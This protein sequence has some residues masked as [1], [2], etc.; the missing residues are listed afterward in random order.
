M[1]LK[2]VH[3]TNGTLSNMHSISLQSSDSSI[4]VNDILGRIGFAASNETGSDA[5][6]V[7]ALILA[8]AE[9]TFDTNNNPTSLTFSTGHSETATEKMRIDS[10]GNVGIGT[11]YTSNGKLTVVD[12]EN[13]RVSIDTGGNFGS[14]EIGIDFIDRHNTSS[15]GDEGQIGAF[16]RS[17]RQGTGGSFDLILGTVDGS[18]LA[19]D[20]DEK[21][22]I[23]SEGK[24]GIA[25]DNPANKLHI[26]EDSSYLSENSYAIKISDGNDPETHGML[27]GVDSTNNIASIQA[28]DPGTSWGRNL[29]LQVMGG[30]L[31][32]GTTAPTEKLHLAGG[33]ILLSA[34]AGSGGGIGKADDG[35]HILFP[36]GGTYGGGSAPSVTGYIKIKLPVKSTSTM[37]AFDL[38]IYEYEDDVNGRIAKFRIAGYEYNA[39]NW[40][41]T[42][43]VMDSD[44]PT[45]NKYKVTF[46]VDTNGDKAIWISYYSDGKDGVDQ[47]GSSLWRYPKVSMSNLFCGHSS[48]VFTNWADGWDVGIVAASDIGSIYTSHV[49]SRSLKLYESS[50]DLASLTINSDYT[51]PTVDGS[52]NQL[53]KTNGAG[54]LSFGS[55]DDLLHGYPINYATSVGWVEGSGSQAG[56][57]GGDFG[58]NGASAENFCEFGDFPNSM[59]GLI[60]KSRNNT[61]DSGADGGWNKDI[62]G[63]DPEKTYISIV[64]VRRVGSNTNGSFYHG[65]GSTSGQTETLAGVSTT[66]PYFHSGGLAGLPQDVWCV[67]IGIIHAHSDPVTTST[68]VGGVYRLDTGAR[69]NFS[70][71]QDFRMGPST[72]T[73]RHRTYLYYDATGNSKL[74]WCWPGFYDITSPVVINLLNNLL[75]GNA[76]NIDINDFN[77]SS[78]ITESEGIS[79]NDNDTTLPTSAAVKDY[80]DNNGGSSSNL[81]RGSFAVTSSTTVFTVSGGYNTGSL[82]VYQNGIKLFKGS[83]YDYTET[84]GGTT[85]TLTN[86]ATNGDLIEYVA[87]NASTNAVGNTS[88]GSVSVTSNQTV[89][90]TTD[91]FTSSNLAV[92]LNGV[93]LVDGTDYN[94]TSSSQFTL[95]ST[96]VSGDIVEYIAYGATVASSNLSKTGDTMTGNLTVNADLIVTGYKETHTDNGNT[97]TSQTI[98]IS[99]STLQTYT[100]TGNCTFTMPTA[101]EGRSFTMFLKTGAGSFVATFTNAKFARNSTPTITT[102]ANRM[103]IITFYSDGTNWYGSIQQEYHI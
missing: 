23:T 18:T 4:A 58:R 15:Q 33:N 41:R 82:D 30:N 63:L 1:L 50:Y 31:G 17:Q 87:I 8:V 21:V 37:I 40:T 74:D 19:A 20:A 53:L 60:W 61:T 72:T 12:G 88:L 52:A 39:T 10:I 65:C 100:L 101:E 16:V 90:N 7:S 13:T 24:V 83:S 67:S 42:Q 35:L 26:R 96:A 85:F 86:A 81:I 6:K 32:V 51:F 46:G 38:D 14:S 22:R 45:D 49:V 84:G 28:V 36:G 29:S 92:F 62:E 89:F 59:R 3:L 48:P 73:Q 54:A 95:T 91:T 78:I 5:L 64:Y 71:H 11:T 98:D 99:D 34:S 93:K 43:V 69:I 102:D 55:V 56:Y 75:Y 47:A 66:N 9:G 97:G 2:L 68:G 94:V 27:L 76:S 70:N 103:D 79:S 77:A 44:G 80:V 57:Y 25:T